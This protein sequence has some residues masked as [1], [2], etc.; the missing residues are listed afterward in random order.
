LH[1]TDAPQTVDRVIDVFPPQQQAMVRTQLGGVLAAVVCQTL[2]P[3][4]GG[5]GR[6]AAR[7]IMITNPAIA[8]L[9]RDNQ[10]HQLAGAIATGIAKGMC[11]LELS[12][13]N[14]VL[15]GLVDV[16]D[17]MAAANRPHILEEYLKTK[18][19]G[20]AAQTTTGVA[21]APV[22][23]APAA[24]QPQKSGFMSWGKK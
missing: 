8:H 6:V 16:E 3:K 4:V 21:A 13:A 14:K 18:G 15:E 20:I 2:L 19:G 12:L 24:A 23:A 11:P 7:E 22:Q 17:A 10:T 1:T 9:I 5:K